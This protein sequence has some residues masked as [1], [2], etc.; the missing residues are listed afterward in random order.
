MLDTLYSAVLSDATALGLFVAALSLVAW[1]LGYLFISFATA[2][3]R[4]PE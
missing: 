3:G 1:C 2:V 4:R